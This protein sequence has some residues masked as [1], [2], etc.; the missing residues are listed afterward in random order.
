[1]PAGF[2]DELLRRAGPELAHAR[3]ELTP[4]GLFRLRL[5]RLKVGHFVEISRRTADQHF[6]AFD[7]DGQRIER[8]SFTRPIDAEAA[9]RIVERAV[10]HADEMA[11][12]V[13]EKLIAHEIER[14]RHMPAAVHVGAKIAAVIDQKRVDTILPAYQPEFS[15]GAGLHLADARD[16]AAAVPAFP[17]HPAFLTDKVVAPNDESDEKETEKKN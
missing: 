2:D 9:F 7:A 6:I 12:V 10:R 5:H 16:D 1:M 11:A 14:R 4:H 8:L 15:D 17:L 13:G 3:D